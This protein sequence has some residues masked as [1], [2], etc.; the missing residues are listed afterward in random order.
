MMNGRRRQ[1]LES[2]VPLGSQCLIDD[3][4]ALQEAYDL[5]QDYGMDSISTGGVMAFGIEAF[6]K[7][8]ITERETEGITLGWGNA[9][10]LVRMVR[11][12][13][14]REGFGEVLGEGVKRAAQS[15]GG[16]ASEYAI[17]VKGLEL[18]LHDPRSSNM[19]ALEYATASRGADHVSAYG[20]ADR[21]ISPELGILHDRSTLENRFK[22]EGQAEAVSKM[23]DYMCLFNSLILCIFLCRVQ[24]GTVGAQPSLL[25]EWVRHAT[26][27]DMDS[28]ELLQAGERIFNL[29]RLFNVRRGLSRKDD[30]LPPR[31]LT[32]KRGGT[33][34][35][36]DKVPPLGEMLGRYYQFRGW[37]EEGIPTPQKIAELGLDF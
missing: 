14:E 17:H 2:M 22:V 24:Y 19:L 20:I 36:A 31:I 27:W 6:E 4:E 16:L 1:V 10:S 35:A 37:T 29:Q 9:K 23:Q 25:A 3:V 5:C 33:T 34:D 15:L 28:K 12:I 8:L 26:G 13:G 30:I 21:Y 11:K 32:H 7:G 18:P